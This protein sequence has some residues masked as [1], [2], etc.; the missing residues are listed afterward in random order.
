M[1]GLRQLALC[2]LTAASAFAL[3]AGLGAHP[4]VERSGEALADLLALK[5]GQPVR[6]YAWHA[7]VAL[8]DT[9]DVLSVQ[10]QSDAQVRIALA[11]PGRD[12]GRDLAHYD[13]PPMSQ[14]RIIDTSRPDP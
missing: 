6:D 14:A 11:P 2:Y 12:D 3:L 7:G 1:S 10:G 5:V 8:L 4:D 9:P 13:R